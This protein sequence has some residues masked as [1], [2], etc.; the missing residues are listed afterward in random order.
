MIESTPCENKSSKLSIGAIIKNLKLL[1][2]VSDKLKTKNMFKHVLVK[3]LPFVIRYFLDQKT[4]EICHKAIL[5][6]GQMLDCYKM[7]NV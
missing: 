3:K 2:F 6:N 1:K 5:E 4:Q 7:K